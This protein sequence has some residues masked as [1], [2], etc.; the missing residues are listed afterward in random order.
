MCVSIQGQ[1]GAGA[2]PPC[3]A[4]AYAGRSRPRVKV[5]PRLGQTQYQKQTK[6]S[7]D[8]DHKCLSK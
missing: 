7:T 4:A 6:D 3:R 5:G 1:P 8:S 2:T